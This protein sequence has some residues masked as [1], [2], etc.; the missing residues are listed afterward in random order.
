MVRT[1]NLRE[2]RLGRLPSDWLT[3]LKSD[4]Y[5]SATKKVDN[6]FRTFAQKSSSTELET[7]DGISAELVKGLKKVLRRDDISMEYVDNGYFKECS[8]LTIGDFK[9]ALLTFFEKFGMQPGDE[10]LFGK[11]FE[12]QSIFFTYKKMPHG[13]MAKPFMSSFSTDYDE[14]GYMLNKFI[15]KNDKARA[16]T[17]LNP[18]RAK[19][20]E[21]SI[22]D[23]ERESNMINNIII[24]A[25]GIVKN[26][27]YIKDKDFRR[28][29]FVFLDR[30]F[31]E[32]VREDAIWTAHK[33]KDIDSAFRVEKFLI[34]QMNNGTDI[35][36]ADLRELLK[37]MSEE[38]RLRA[39]RMLRRFR[40]TH[41]LKC[42]LKANGAYDQFKPYLEKAR[43]YLNS[44]GVLA[45]ELE[46][47]NFD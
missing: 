5:C 35:Y 37:P 26:G 7:L 44:R 16:M 32:Y 24:D 21:Y 29:L 10:R 13:R 1:Q 2:R 4:E 11:Y 46:I 41:K 30:I 18:L 14:Y 19:Y 45:R 31:S 22:P 34:D 42:E 27:A 47:E 3:N 39:T 20:R 43:G 38:D 17:P 6:L 33:Y 36:K 28:N 15:D 8:K 23:I 40:N 9:Y 25:G 12:P